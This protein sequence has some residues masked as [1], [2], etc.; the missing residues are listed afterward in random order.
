MTTRVFAGARPHARRARGNSV[1]G[2]TISLAL[3]LI[4][5]H[6]VSPQANAQFVAYNDHY[7][8]PGTHANATVWNAF[9]TTGGAPGNSGFLRNITNG[10]NLPVTLAINTSGVS[11]GATS[12][13]PSA[14]TPAYNLFNNFV[15]FGSGTLGHAIQT[16]VGATVSHVFTGLDPNKRYH[17]RGTAVRGDATYTNR[18]ILAEL[19]GASSF[20]RAHTSGVITSNQEPSLSLAQAAMN[21]GV[22]LNGDMIGWDNIDPG[23]DGSVTITQTQYTGPAPGNSPIGSYGYSFVAIRLEEV[24]AV[25]IPASITSQ[26]SDQTVTENAPATFTVGLSGIPTPVVQWYRDGVAI[27]GATGPTYVL[28][29]AKTNDNGTVFRAIANNIAS[30]VA[31]SVTS[32]VATLTVI[33][34]NTAPALIKAT[35]VASTQ[36]L[37]TFSEPLLPSTVTNLANYAVTSAGGSLI[38]SN[39]MLQADET[40]VLLITSVHAQSVAYTVTVNNIKDLAAAGNVIAPNSQASFF[41]A[42]GY[43]GTDIGNPA[44]PGTITPVMNGYNITSSGVDIGTNSDQF[45]FAYQQRSGPFDF[46]VRVEGLSL[47]DP[48]AKAGLMV[49]Q[50]L[51]TNSAYGAILATPSIAGIVFQSRASASAGTVISSNTFPVNYPYTWLRL[52]RSGNTITGYGSMDG[53]SWVVVGSANVTL[54]DPVY[55][56][57]AVSSRTNQPVTANFRDIASATGSV[58][59]NFVLPFEPLASSTRRTALLIS[60]I[61]YHP[62]PR[63]DSNSLEFVEIYNS[64]AFYEDISGHRLSGDIDF[65]FPPGTILPSGGFAVVA[66]N[67]AA[68]QAA[69]SLSGVA[70]FGPYT[71]NLPN[72]KGTIRLRDELDAVLLEVEYDTRKPWPLAP[73]GTGHSMVLAR[74]SYGE[75]QPEAWAQSDVKGGSPGALESYGPE[76]LRPVVINEYLAHTDLPQLDFIELFNRSSQP[77]DLSGAYL[78]DSFETNKFRIPNGTVIP[79]RGFVTF[80]EYDLGFALSSGGESIYLVN[81]NNTRVIDCVRFEGQENGVSAGRFPDGA[82]RFHELT[83]PTFNLPN[84]NTA[85][86]SRAIVINEIM[87]NPISGSDD[88]EYIELYNKGTNAVD[89][90]GWAFTRGINFSFPS[91]TVLGPD[92]YLVVAKNKTNLLSRYSNLNAGNTVGN[93]SGSLKNGG[94]WLAL[95]MPDQVITSLTTNGSIITTNFGL[96]YIVVD[97]VVYKDGGRW[98]KWADGGGSSLELIDP[99][100]DNRLPSNWADSDETGKGEWTAVSFTGLMDNGFNN[101]SIVADNL[102][103]FL[104]DDGEC[105]VDDVQVIIGTSNILANSNFESNPLNGTDWIIGG[106]HESTYWETN[107]GYNSQGSLHLVAA[108]RGDTGPNKARGRFTQVAA[109]GTGP[110]TPCTINAQVRW[111]KGTRDILFRMKGNYIEAPLR[112]N[113]PLNTGTPGAPNSRRIANAGPAI[114]EVVHTP[115]LPAA[116]QPVVVTAR[117]TDPDGIGSFNVIYRNDTL[118]SAPVT[119]PMVDNGTSGDAVAG[120]GLYSATIP[121]MNGG[122]LA[123]FYLRATDANTNAASATFPN[124]APA[125]ECLVRFGEPTQY[126]AFASYRIWC[127]TA[128]VNRWTSRDK[129]SNKPLDGTFVYN[130]YRVIYNAETYYSGSPF[131][132]PGYSGPNGGVCDYL[133]VAPKDDLFLGTTD[134]IFASL[135]N[136][137]N[138]ATCQAEQMAFWIGRKIGA[139]YNY[140]RYFNMYFNGLRRGRIYE[141]AQQP[142]SDMLSQYFPN[143]NDGNLHKIEDWFEYSDDTGNSA[144][145]RF[146]V[147]ATL[148]LFNSGGQKKLARYR[149]TFRARAVQDSPNDYQPLFDLVD[150]L[151]APTNEPFHTMV[152]NNIDVEQWMR[153]FTTE[154]IAGNWDS[155]GY[156]RG[157]NMYCYKPRNDGWKLMMWD[158]DM[159]LAQGARAFDADIYSETNDGLI[160]KLKKHPPFTRAFYRALQD[161]VNG[162]MQSA[163]AEQ[164]MNARYAALLA[165]GINATAPTAHLTYIANRRNYLLTNPANGLNNTVAAPFNINLPG[166]VLSVTNNNVITLSGTAPIEAR[167]ILINGIEYP[168]TWTSVTNWTLRLVVGSSNNVLAFQGINNKGQALTNVTGSVT[169]NFYGSIPQAQGTVVINEIMYRPAA[170]PLASYIELWNTSPSFSFDLSGW[171]LNGLGYTFPAGTFLTNRQFLVLAKNRGAFAAAYG[172]STNVLDEFDGELDTDGETLTLIRP[173]GT[174]EVV[175]DKVRYETKA[176][177]P[178]SANGAGASLQLIDASQDNARVSNWSDGSTWRYYVN[179][180]LRVGTNLDLWLTAANSDLYIDNLFLAAGSTP[181]SGPNLIYNGGFELGTNGYR[182]QGGHTNSTL[183]SNP[184]FSGSNSLYLVSGPSGGAPANRMTLG[185]T[186]AVANATHS[187]SFWYLPT[188]NSVGL[189]VRFANLLSV[190][191]FSVNVAAGSS[192]S[193]GTTNPI[194]ASVPAY[195]LLWLNE[196][197]PENTNGLADRFGETEPW[198]ELYNSGTNIINLS[199]FYLSSGYSDLSEW[200]FPAGAVLL[201]GEFKVIFADGQPEQTLGNEWHTS[202][203]LSA[204]NGSLA[205]VKNGLICDYI[206]YSGVPMNS[207][208]GSYPDGQLFERQIFYFRTPGAP[209]NPAPVPIAINEWMASNTSTIRDPWNN[210]FEDW[211]ELYNFGPSPVDLSGY[212]LTDDLTKRKQFRVPNGIVLAAGGHLL[213]WADGDN[214]GTNLA[215]GALHAGFNLSRSGETIALFSPDGV[216]VD[217]VTYT[218]QNSDIS[219]GRYPDGNVAGV[220][221]SMTQPTPG[222]QNVMQAGNQFAPELAFISDRNVNEG[223]L[224]SFTCAASDADTPAQTLTFSLDVDAPPGAVI[225]PATGLFSWT[226]LEMHGPGIYNIT[227]KVTDNGSPAK[228]DSQTFSVTVNEVNE[229]PVLSAIANRWVSV[230]TLLSVTN[231]VS[232]NDLPANALTFSLDPGTP[233][234]A[235]I[236]P[237]SGLLTWTPSEAQSPST[238]AITVRVTDSGSPPLAATRTFQVVVVSRPR[239]MEISRAANGAVTLR[240]QSYPGMHYRLEHKTNLDDPEWNTLQG[241]D[242]LSATGTETIHTHTP[243]NNAAQQFYRLLQVD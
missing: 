88:D 238:N 24:V 222:A 44:T 154:R 216:L 213:V 142:N 156:N 144:S 6:A 94:D 208:Y 62:A 135:G 46:A 155:Y 108:G 240:W 113:L 95:S 3:G 227:V 71:N 133:L 239:I 39:A 107:G 51:T 92:G 121:G 61:M 115:I 160:D 42:A 9:G 84:T 1:F 98:S 206:N 190:T 140:R 90:G 20:A 214:T 86:L 43:I 114:Y 221:Q 178:E 77:I 174:N 75:G 83:T 128:T 91:N 89:L 225:H 11:S 148:G 181:E 130:N 149:W 186:G 241:A 210:R 119:I 79:A 80:N 10:N 82:P 179:T 162:P 37:L 116:G 60:E 132:T 212:Y 229:S 199:G 70:V 165:N 29:F 73:D 173:A 64:Q 105:L 49:R 96:I 192:F 195:P 26:P 183:S 118:G 120:D 150:T 18:W 202:F 65:T 167:T 205:L 139:P 85:I 168:I 97:E 185:V 55:F 138:E 48:W 146:N 5:T 110:G 35:E 109:T 163:N 63:P 34:D 38:L 191:N 74:A 16:P 220:L 236:H 68:L 166:G 200:A 21:T 147:N 193:P 47:T 67:P 169:V 127:T 184:R 242:S 175:I 102:N 87:Y 59:T 72:D 129:N 69:Y 13:A 93:Y 122:Q 223:A 45:T 54:T 2:R 36:I 211:I 204:T 117:L 180:N 32:S 27:P 145:S 76:P 7:T 230:G 217:S 218:N 243:A 25:E 100:S 99:R 81:S 53:S 228:F 131:H 170:N 176:P 196:I 203:R 8:G 104:Q 15:D 106:T 234:G 41:S 58:M 215:G 157:K 31:Y 52:Q 182:F 158:I 194:I 14:G 22:N 235:F 56:G 201:P 111:L 134:F 126:G 198:I 171:R 50:S 237:S 136:L 231:F 40:N 159:V 12:G 123:A 197:Q 30:N 143:D 164:I 188:T 209:N 17:F 152:R 33:P 19:V 172:S 207:A 57:Y 232:D 125:R 226:P 224:L 28:P 137:D 219:Q 189:N 177:W 103:V 153:V 233:A 112:M 78:S 124:D 187:L 161:A 66:R 4:C 23:P 141:D 101:A 151:N